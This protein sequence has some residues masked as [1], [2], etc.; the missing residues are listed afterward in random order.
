MMHLPE[1]FAIGHWTDSAALTG[2]T[3]V[4]CPPNTVGGC[5]VRGNSPGSRE[6]VL[7]ASE[8]SM[9]EVH[10][11]LLAGGSA[12]GLAA[13]D[14]VMRYLEE[15]GIG[16]QTPWGRVP[17]VPAAVVFDLNI[18]SPTVRPS[19]AAGYEA[20][21][22]ADAEEN[23]MG[24]VGAGVGATVG[25]WAGTDARMRGGF[26]MADV[27]HESLKVAA[28]AVVNAVGDVLDEEGKVLAGA[29]TREGAWVAREDALR[30]M[31]VSQTNPLQ[32]MNTT[33]VAVITNAHLS[34]VDANR[35]AQR[36]HDGLARAI[37]PVHTMYD[38]DVVFALASGNVEASVDL[39]AEAGADAAVR[40]IR[41]AVRS[42]SPH[43][44]VRS[45]SS[46]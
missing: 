12:F 36:G 21:A 45:V 19:A 37:K 16:Y 2:C 1:G 31:R 5:D 24:S 46:L 4:L 34:K 28:V 20:C 8:K 10:A 13:A 41:Q 30:R 7:L 35:V 9:Q 11:I 40:A 6:L 43:P 18:G 42:A 15:H 32:M 23:R 29:R 26:G 14:G 39:V 3:V 17:I 33:L 27:V 22:H 25:K 38:G 44:S